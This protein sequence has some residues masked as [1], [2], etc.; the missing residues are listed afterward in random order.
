MIGAK[1]RMQSDYSLDDLTK[2]N[3]DLVVYRALAKD[4]TPFA[5]TRMRFESEIVEVLA[6]EGIFENALSELREL[7][8]EHVRPVLEG[9]MDE[10]DHSPWV[11][12]NWFDGKPLSARTI[13]LRDIRNI[14]T[15]LHAVVADLGPRA[16]VLCFE[17][18]EILTIRT[19]DDVLHVLFTIDY[20]CWFRDYGRGFPPGTGR[21]ASA[22]ARVLLE[23]LVTKQQRHPGTPA[24]TPIPFVEERSPA[25]QEYKAPRE[26]YLGK[27]LLFLA[28]LSSLGAI[29]FLTLLGEE[30]AAESGE[31]DGEIN[32][33]G[34]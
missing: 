1:H 15:Q 24:G 5:L 12:S 33:V 26:R 13:S 27:V 7:R 14:G 18:D 32:A 22:E 19:P 11:V 23:G 34:R 17:A 6:S 3:A 4:G 20:Y 9:G 28:L 29:I 10:V 30:K 16:D 2:Q 31:L 21:D 25:L 8:H